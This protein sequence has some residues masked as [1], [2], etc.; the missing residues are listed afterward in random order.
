MTT[1]GSLSRDLAP[2]NEV[3]GKSSINLPPSPTNSVPY[4]IATSADDDKAKKP[5]V[6]PINGGSPMR[7]LQQCSNKLDMEPNPFEQSFATGSQ[8]GGSSNAIVTSTAAT[9]STTTS[10]TANG[11]SE[12]NAETPK[13]VLP[14][15]EAM[16][17]RLAPGTDQF[18]WDAQSLRM[19]PLS[20]S[21]L[22]GPQNPIV[23]D[24]KTTQNPLPLGSFPPPS[25]S[26]SNIFT[27][28]APLADNG[29]PFVGAPGPL[30]VPAVALHTSEPYSSSTYNPSHSLTSHQQQS[31]QH[32]GGGGPGSR[33]SQNYSNQNNHAP[34]M[35]DSYNMS[36]QGPQHVDNMNG[37][38]NLHLLSQAQATHREMWVKREGSDANGNGPSGQQNLHQ[39]HHSHGPP[40]PPPHISSQSR[41]NA[42]PTSG[43]AQSGQ[44]LPGMPGMVAAP[45]LPKNGV[46]PA[47][48]RGVRR[49]R[50]TSEDNSD[51]SEQSKSGYG[52]EGATNNS[53]N[54]NNNSNTNGSA[55][56]KQNTGT[57]DDKMDEEEKRK[58]FLE[59]NR[60][61]ALKC[62]QRKK[63]WLANLQQKV[64]YLTTDNEHLQSQTA[65][66]RDEIIHLKAL[67]LAHKD[68]P[69]AQANGVF[70]DTISMVN[71]AGMMGHDR[72]GYPMPPQHG[73]A[74]PPGPPRSSLPPPPL[75][76]QGHMPG[77][78]GPRMG[79]PPVSSSNGPP[80]GPS[81]PMSMM[82]DITPSAS[83]SQGQVNVR[84]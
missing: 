78:G 30:P 41:V 55:K 79:H 3:S 33:P 5:V 49:S 50:M 26:I 27:S 8:K 34:S 18:G 54:D 52:G 32:Q 73:R 17:G 13:P 66:L 20:P 23:F 69:I 51:D 80:P 28:G 65:A 24:E 39:Q 60:Q 58:N 21:M 71:H 46:E 19:G 35:N 43:P 77:G 45:Q 42:H 44:S 12:P 22:E 56:K 62:R 63:Q 61:A 76:H 9:T 84:Y 82:Q 7:Y 1:V 29:L 25:S 67:L 31:S 81:R 40:P 36:S 14:P 57:G 68:C 2:G 70:A 38:G 75:H 64:E 48:V 4:I 15:I 59:R 16:S 10:T 47:F 83:P 6:A 74:G 37:Y 53:N 11:S 72:S